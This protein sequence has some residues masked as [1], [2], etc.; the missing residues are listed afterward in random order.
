M[1]RNRGID[2][3]PGPYVHLPKQYKSYE[4]PRDVAVAGLAAAG[5]KTTT[6]S[7][8][9]LQRRAFEAMTAFAHME[10]QWWQ[11][12]LESQSKAEQWQRS[13]NAALAADANATYYW[14]HAEQALK[15]VDTS[16]QVILKE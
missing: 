6:T 15:H 4:G 16:T 3:R 14:P 11:R 5:L 13:I 7:T 10:L 2:E 12:Q 9:G 8:R 1:W